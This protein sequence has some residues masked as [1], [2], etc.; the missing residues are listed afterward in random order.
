MVDTG[1]VRVAEDHRPAGVEAEQGRAQ[2]GVGVQVHLPLRPVDDPGVDLVRQHPVVAYGGGQYRP[3]I[4]RDGSAWSGWSAW[5][6]WSGWSAWLGDCAGSARGPAGRGRAKPVPSPFGPD[7]S[8]C[9]RLTDLSSS[10]ADPAP[11]SLSRHLKVHRARLHPHSIPRRS[12]QT[13][14]AGRRLGAF[15]GPRHKNPT[16][17]RSSRIRSRTPPH[18]PH[19]DAMRRSSP[20]D[21]GADP[22]ATNKRTFGRHKTLLFNLSFDAK[23]P[24]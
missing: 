5:L 17:P 13:R 4:P 10:M 3:S 11:S 19:E 23:W 7:S 16:A 2:V 15:L 18:A 21:G 8:P 20:P 9:N 24:V 6:A 22:A 1:H 12:A 14:F